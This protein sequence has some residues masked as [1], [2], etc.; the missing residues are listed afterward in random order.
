VK[1]EILVT[2]DPWQTRIALLEDGRLM[3]FFQEPRHLEGLVGNLYLGKVSRILPGM[4]SAFVDIG[5]DRDGF[6]FEGDMGPIGELDDED[7]GGPAPSRAVSVKELRDGEPILVQ[8]T[9][10][11]MGSKGARLTTQISVP[12]HYLIYMPHTEHVGVSRKISG[13]ERARLKAAVRGLKGESPGAFIVRTAAEGVAEEDL[14]VEMQSLVELWSLVRLR[15]M[16]LAAPSLVHQEAD[17]VGRTVREIL[18]KGEGVVVTDDAETAR[19]C[20]SILAS[21]G[22][23]PE[24]VQEWTEPRVTL[25]EHHRVEQE[26]EKALQ[27]RVWLPSGGCIVVQSTEALVSVDVNSGR[28]VGK[29]SL[30]ETAFLINGEA[31]EEVVRQLR[32]R[33]LGGIIVIDFIDMTKRAHREALLAKLQAALQSDRSRSRILAISEFGLVEMTRK[34]THKSLERVMTATCPCCEGR[35]R[36]VAAWRTAQTILQAAGNLRKPVRAIVTAPADVVKYLEENRERLEI[37]PGL[38]FEVAPHPRP[39]RYDIRPL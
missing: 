31:A 32:L 4:A 10:E 30:E 11:P 38:K 1:Q 33:S 28:F 14:A 21:L 20:R 15:S 13:P 25:F 23:D 8:V 2:A 7:E 22:Q 24:R 3:E 9:K 39:N 16:R 37:P 26:L 19:R 27:A 17:L 29:K 36:V 6:L 34:R 12:G 18:L 35:G 5:L